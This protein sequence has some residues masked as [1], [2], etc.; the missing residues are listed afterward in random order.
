MEAIF[1]LVNL[2]NFYNNI[3]YSIPFPGKYDNNEYLYNN[4][5]Q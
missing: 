5:N 3:Y 1:T 4:K 2:V